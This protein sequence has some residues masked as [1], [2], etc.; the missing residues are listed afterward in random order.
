MITL[1][2]EN[3]AK[4]LEIS[5]WNWM[6]LVRG[7]RQR[8]GGRRES[9]AFLLGLKLGNVLQVK[10]IVFYEELDPDAY[11]NGIIM[12]HARGLSA[13]WAV[14]RSLRLEVVADCHTHGN[15][16]T[17]Q[18]LTDQRNPMIPEIGHMAM[19]IPFFAQIAAW[20]IRGIGIHE[21]LGN[22]QWR[23]DDSNGVSDFI[24]LKLW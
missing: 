19:I 23:R 18:S 12:F 20:S 13:L 22:F 21:Y 5:I 4:R 10:R 7:L 17:S 11:Q 2:N 24:E 15:Q 16:N 14:C 3:Q 6:R 9:G 8:G 1:G